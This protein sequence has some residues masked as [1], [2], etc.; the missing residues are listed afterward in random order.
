M[1]EQAPEWDPEVTQQTIL[2]MLM[3]LYDVEM[4]IL[5]ELN[6]DRAEILEK[7]HD[8]GGIITEFPW[9]SQDTPT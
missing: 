7:I 3:R 9:L 5:S 4:S 8:K 2:L 6:D 1:V